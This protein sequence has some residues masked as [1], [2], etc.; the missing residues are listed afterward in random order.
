M[1]N[2]DERWYKAVDQLLGGKRGPCFFCDGS[3]VDPT[4]AGKDERKDG[5]SEAQISYMCEHAKN[6]IIG[7]P[8]SAQTYAEAELMINEILRDEGFDWLEVIEN[9]NIESTTTLNLSI[10]KR[11]CPMCTKDI[12]RLNTYRGRLREYVD[13]HRPR[14]LDNETKEVDKVDSRQ[15]TS[16]GLYIPEAVQ[17]VRR[18]EKS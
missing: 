4:V 17:T 6:R 1:A 14:E 7:K 13:N 3:G 16:T 2:D 8:I 10:V 11:R 5:P 9:K 18:K 12:N 15:H